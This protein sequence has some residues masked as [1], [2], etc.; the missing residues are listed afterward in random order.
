MKSILL[1]EDDANLNRGIA[2]T[3][4]KEGYRVFSAYSVKEAEEIF[5]KETLA[6]VISDITLPD[7]DGL[8][9]GKKVRERSRVCLVYLTAL[10][11]EFDIVNGYATGA[12]D[13]ITK[14]FSLMVL[15][16]KINAIMR[17][18]S[19]IQSE[20]FIAGDIEVHSKEGQVFQGGEQVI[21]SKTEWKLLLCFLENAGQILSKE[22]ILQYVW[23]NDGQFVEDNI[24]TVNISR[25]KK[26]LRTEH[27]SNVRG[28]GYLWDGQVIRN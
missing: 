6:M 1:L 5:E 25:L 28:L 22:Q 17:R 13:Y 14:P 24:V 15:T 18:L 19:G 21:L 27:I 12:D 3:L 23:G 20:V 26:K 10:D 16:S 2:L 4:Q 7:G 9:F 8:S 11:Q